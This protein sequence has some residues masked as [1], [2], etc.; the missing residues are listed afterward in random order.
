[1]EYPLHRQLTIPRVSRS[2]FIFSVIFLSICYFVSVCRALEQTHSLTSFG[3]SVGSWGL[4]MCVAVKRWL[5]K[6]Q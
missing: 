4:A 6:I 5:T 1:L 2:V 3:F